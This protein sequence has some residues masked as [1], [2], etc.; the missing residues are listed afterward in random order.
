LLA[1][2]FVFLL[3]ER[4]EQFFHLAVIVQ[5]HRQHGAL[6]HRDFSFVHEALR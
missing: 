5:Q 1:G 4:L 2:R 6:R 3:L